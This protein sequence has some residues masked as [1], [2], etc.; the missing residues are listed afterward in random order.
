MSTVQ[1]VIVAAVVVFGLF[2]WMRRS[3]NAKSRQRA[4]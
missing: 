4:R 1:I 3:A 2:Y